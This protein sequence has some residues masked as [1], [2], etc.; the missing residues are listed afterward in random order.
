[1]LPPTTYPSATTTTLTCDDSGA[2]STPPGTDDLSA[3]G[4]TFSET[5]GVVSRPAFELTEN[6]AAHPFQKVFLYVSLDAAPQTRLTITDPPDA[7]LYYVPEST[8]QSR[9]TDAQVLS[10]LTKSVTVSRCESDFTGYFGG[11]VLGSGP[12]VTLRVDPLPA[13]TSTTLT[14]QLPGPC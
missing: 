11:I 9:Q 12:C 1:M 13:G 3:N 6:S 10:S 7:Y 5:S 4:L 14:V 2:A 8:W